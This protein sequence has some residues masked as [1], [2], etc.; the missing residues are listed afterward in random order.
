VGRDEASPAPE[1]IRLADLL[2]AEQD[3]RRRLALFLHD[4]PVQTLSGV[5]L[6]LDAV[7][8]S[9]AD[10]R[11]DEATK[12]LSQALALHRDVIR[13]LRDL[14]F[15]LEPVVLRDRGIASAVAAL[16]DEMSSAHNID[17]EVDV[18]IAEHLEEKVQA[19]LYQIVRETLNSAVRRL[20]PPTS[21]S[22]VV[23]RAADGRFVTTISDDGAEE[24]RS[25]FFDRLGDRARSLGARISF[26]TRG[27]TK[28]VLELPA[29]AA[30]D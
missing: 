9:I 4:G 26:E 18:A 22:I 27:G 11:P 8:H 30:A 17:F 10:D 23:T 21:I 14:S 16:V 29:S 24:R 6:M 15:S 28:I 12:I 3:E 13:S 5:A 19:A 7:A 2:I 25:A 1:G 20:P